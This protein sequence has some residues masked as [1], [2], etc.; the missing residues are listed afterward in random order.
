M[1]RYVARVTL[2]TLI[3]VSLFFTV[4][5]TNSRA[6]SQQQDRL[7]VRKPWPIEPVKVVA[8]NTKK[9]E[10]IEIGRAFDEDD[11]WRGLHGHCLQQLR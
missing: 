1:K 3:G 4:W 9:K 8:V 2:I 10:N 7:V 5:L 6:V 11:D